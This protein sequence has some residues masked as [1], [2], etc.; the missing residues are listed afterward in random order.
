MTGRELITV[1]ERLSKP[2]VFL[3]DSGRADEL[4]G[5]W[6]G[7]GLVSAPRGPYRH[8]LS[9]DCRFIP[10]GL[11]PRR[12]L[13]SIYIDTEKGEGGAVAVDL[14]GAVS[15]L[16]G[17]KPLY[18]IAGRSL[19]PIDAIFRFGGDSV[20]EWLREQGWEPNWGYSDNF[21]DPE[22]VHEY[23]RLYQ[24]ECPLYTSGAFAVL[25]GWHF[26]WPDND[27]EERLAEQLLVWTFEESE[28]WVEVWG[29]SSGYRVLQRIT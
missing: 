29:T 6:G 27:W 4:A 14:S 18:A 20:H 3:T 10:E 17:R 8:W 2:C 13:F 11:G 21:K 22:P 12:G 19:P 1:G 15:P 5:F 23:E 28:P 7:E 9:F 16:D 24:G 26:P 25:G